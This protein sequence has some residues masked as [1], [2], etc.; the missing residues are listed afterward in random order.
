MPSQILEEF[1]GTYD[2][3]WPADTVDENFE[4]ADEEDYEYSSCENMWC[5]RRLSQ[6]CLVDLSSASTKE[7]RGDLARNLPRLAL[8]ETGIFPPNVVLYG[9]LQPVCVSNRTIFV[10]ISNLERWVVNRSKEGRGYWIVTDSTTYYWLQDPCCQKIG[11]QFTSQETLHL[12]HRISLG[13]LSIIIDWL[14]NLSDD[15]VAKASRLSPQVLIAQICDS[16]SARAKSNYKLPSWEDFESYGHFL[17]IHLTAL[18]HTLSVKCPLVL[19]LLK[20]EQETL[21]SRKNKT[22]PTDICYE[23]QPTP[24]ECND[25]FARQE[26][27]MRFSLSAVESQKVDNKLH[28]LKNLSQFAFH[29]EQLTLQ[30]SWGQPILSSVPKN[31]S[32]GSSHDLRDTTP[33]KSNHLE[34]NDSGG[35]FAPEQGRVEQELDRSLASVEYKF[36]SPDKANSSESDHSIQ[37]SIITSDTSK[38]TSL[39]NDE[40]QNET[41]RGNVF[42]FRRDGEAVS[43]RISDLSMC[44]SRVLDLAKAADPFQTVFGQ[45]LEQIGTDEVVQVRAGLLY[46]TLEHLSGLTAQDIIEVSPVPDISHGYYWN[47]QQ[48]YE[49]EL[50]VEIVST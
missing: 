23:K 37:P 15:E 30:R 21:S 1:Q 8:P 3:P 28:I 27:R 47:E 10:R 13:L 40:F 41:Q 19:G 7:E 35:S 46:F 33:P 14:S 11:G 32:K 4:N 22:T 5:T 18:R 44:M 31:V 49:V 6:W 20:A 9:W 16:L 12:N 50:E 38:D 17:G 45:Q 43:V 36:K 2:H 34:T 42:W 29:L 25:Y 39:Q 26:K 24:T 48:P